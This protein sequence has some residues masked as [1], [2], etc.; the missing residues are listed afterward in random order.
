[1][2]CKVII[3]FLLIC[4]FVFAESVQVENQKGRVCILSYKSA[5]K[6]DLSASLTKDLQSAGYSVTIEDMLKGGDYNAGDFGAVILLSGMYMGK[7]RSEAADY[8][9]ANNYAPNIVYVYTHSIEGSPYG[10]KGNVLDK[11]RIDVITSAS[12]SRKS[13]EFAELK[14]TI[15]KATMRILKK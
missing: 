8:I 12:V 4:T 1:M 11:N 2:K 13:E 6:D 7:V 5:F 3:F 14:V 10:K 9:K 15:L